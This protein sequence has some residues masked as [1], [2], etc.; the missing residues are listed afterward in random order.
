MD[1]TPTT[2][3]IPPLRPPS[4]PRRTGP[5]WAWTR[6]ARWRRSPPPCRTRAPRGRRGSSRASCCCC[7]PRAADCLPP[8]RLNEAMIF[9]NFPFK[10][11]QPQFRLEQL[12]VAQQFSARE[13][14]SGP[15]PTKT[16]FH[17]YIKTGWCHPLSWSK[18]NCSIKYKSTHAFHCYYFQEQLVTWCVLTT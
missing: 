15:V 11:L 17:S 9:T 12:T 6:A 1:T 18:F 14:S 4:P 13:D 16:P 3:Y 10:K 5:A 2:R 7:S 8:R